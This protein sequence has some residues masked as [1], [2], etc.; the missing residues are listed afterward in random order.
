MNC[1]KIP[2]DVKPEDTLCTK[3]TTSEKA[4]TKAKANAPIAKPPILG[5]FGSLSLTLVHILFSSCPWTLYVIRLNFEEVFQRQPEHP[6]E[7]DDEP[8]HEGAAGDD[9]DHQHVVLD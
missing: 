2:T 5:S 8:E 1:P 6:P 9:E 4:K 3:R 7:D